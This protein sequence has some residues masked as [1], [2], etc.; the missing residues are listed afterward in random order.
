V[1]TRRFG[2]VAFQQAGQLSRPSS[3]IR[4][5]RLLDLDAQRDDQY[6]DRQAVAEEIAFSGRMCSKH[7]GLPIDVTRRSIEETAAAIMSLFADAACR[8]TDVAGVRPVRIQVRKLSRD[9]NQ[10]APE[11]TPTHP[12]PTPTTPARCWITAP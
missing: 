4:Q 6:M 8:C 7:E 5:N 12:A 11:A 9:L 10:G 1:L 3:H 2:R